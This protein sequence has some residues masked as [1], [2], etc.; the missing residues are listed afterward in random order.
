MK[1]FQTISEV[2]QCVDIWR[3]RGERIALVATMGNLHQGHLTLVREAKQCAD[4]VIVSIFVNPTQFGVNEDFSSYPRTEILD[5]LKLTDE[6]CDAVFLPSVD[7]LYD[8]EAKTSIQ[9]AEI[10][11]YFCGE[12]RRGHFSGVATV[13]CK[14]LNI[15]TPHCALFGLKDFQQF[16]VIQ[17]LVRD[18][19]LPVEILG[20]PTVREGDGLA[21]SSR[22]GYLTPQERD[23]AP[24]IY[25]ILQIARHQIINT[26]ISFTQIQQQSIVNLTE[27]GFEVDYFSVA[28]RADL[29]LASRNDHNLIILVAAKI[30]KTRLIDNLWIDK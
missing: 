19:N 30:G 20:I 15:V 21:M 3:S 22:N 25:K 23:V 13:V 16:L 6:G 11:D 29:M 2:R 1:N 4:R 7:T 5:C 8:S 12:S 24:Q 10:S 18:L 17:T 9:V 27:Y 14:L 28:R 26:S